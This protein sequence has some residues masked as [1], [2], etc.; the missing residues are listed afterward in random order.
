MSA[1]GEWLCVFAVA[2]GGSVLKILCG[3]CAEK[4]VLR[5]CP[6]VSSFPFFL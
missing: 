1:A 2:G 6:C 3:A 4:V 5:A